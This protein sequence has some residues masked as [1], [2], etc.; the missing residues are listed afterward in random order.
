MATLDTANVRRFSWRCWSLAWADA[1]PGKHTITPRA[2]DHDGNVQ[3]AKDNP[4]IANKINLLG[5]SIGNFP[6]VN[7]S[8]YGRCQ[9]AALLSTPPDHLLGLQPE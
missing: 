7:A 5:G 6:M 1:I 4:L 9:A 3:P 8:R 2:I